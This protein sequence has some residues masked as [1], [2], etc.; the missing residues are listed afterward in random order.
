MSSERPFTTGQAAEYCH[1]SQA[2]IVNWIKH[3]KLSGYTT[4]G[5]HY[6]I[7]RSNLVSFL[8]DHEMPI[9]SALRPSSPPR[10]LV[11]SGN[12][13]IREL[14]QT[15]AEDEGFDVLLVSN[16]Y[17]TSAEAVRSQPAAVIIDVSAS[18]D[19]LGLRQWLS[20]TMEN[21]ILLLVDESD[22][23]T[24]VPAALPDLHL[25]PDALPR[26][27]AKLEVLLQ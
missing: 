15:L 3:R 27:E 21:T 23:T 11:L 24:T 18:S 16:D 8:K 10:L 1:V 22:R 25:L 9:D 14:V 13:K 20:E 26:L 12:P 7:P 6:R 17:A 19:P 2:T 4:P 5:G